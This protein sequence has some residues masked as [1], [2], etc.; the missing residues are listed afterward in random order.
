MFDKSISKGAIKEIADKVRADNVHT[1]TH[2][3][4]HTRGLVDVCNELQ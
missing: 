2:T 4:I 1:H 3:H